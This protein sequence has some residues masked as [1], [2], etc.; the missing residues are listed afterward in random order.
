MTSE[1]CLIKYQVYIVASWCSY[2]ILDLT[3]LN[4][5]PL[6]LSIKWA[7]IIR[8]AEASTRFQLF[9]FRK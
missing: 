3:N 1:V 6:F 4:K 7:P 8:W 2:K 9:T 5:I